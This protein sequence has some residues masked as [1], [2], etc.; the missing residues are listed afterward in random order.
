MHVVSVRV[1]IAQEVEIG[2]R[3]ELSGI[4]KE[5]VERAVIAVDGIE[6]DAIVATEFHGGADQ[7]VYLYGADDYAWWEMPEGLFGENLTLSSLGTDDPRV[8]DRYVIGSVVLEVTA[9]RIPCA[10]LGARA[11]DPGFPKRFTAARRPGPYTRVINGGEI[12]P[13]ASVELQR[14][15]D[16]AVTILEVQDLY[17]DRSATA[18]ELER[19]LAAPVAERARE[20]MQRRL[21]RIQRGT[22]DGG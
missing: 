13:G 15:P 1:G 20:S 2:S 14:A 7:A 6:G 4:I 8:G 21:E 16:D 10:K 9:P 3:A 12:V 18:A 5:P 17:H 11:G 22:D 19:A